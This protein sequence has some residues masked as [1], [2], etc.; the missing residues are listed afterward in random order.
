MRLI[1][2][3]PASWASF[4]QLLPPQVAWSPPSSG[5]FIAGD[6]GEVVAG[7]C[8]E[9]AGVHTLFFLWGMDARLAEDPA[10]SAYAMGVIARNARAVLIQTGTLGLFLD[11]PLEAQDALSECGVRALGVPIG[12]LNPHASPP[13]EKPALSSP[14]EDDSEED[15]RPPA[16]DLD[17]ELDEIE[18][19]KAEAASVARPA[20]PARPT[21]RKKKAARKKRGTSLPGV[22]RPR[23]LV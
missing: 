11:P 8:I 16:P 2:Y 7:C 13:A 6:R 18:R 23:S 4:L 12:Y 10:D 20:A 21:V 15:E 5:I 3:S 9:K 17:P 22:P 1:P 14:Q 19:A